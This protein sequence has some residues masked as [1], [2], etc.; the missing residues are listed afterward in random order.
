MNQEWIECSENCAALK[1]WQNV[2]SYWDSPEFF[3]ILHM[4]FTFPKANISEVLQWF[5]KNEQWMCI[6]N[7]QVQVSLHANTLKLSLKRKKYLQ[8]KWFRTCYSL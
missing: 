3:A 5:V 7:E 2:D 4:G 8:S 6:Q 1:K